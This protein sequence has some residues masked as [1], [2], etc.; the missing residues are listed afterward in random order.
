MKHALLLATRA[1][2]FDEVPVGALIVSEGRLIAQDFNRRELNNHPLHHAE[3]SVIDKASRKLKRWRLKGCTLYVTLEPCVMCSG[4]IV[5]SRLDRIVYGAS[6]LMAGGVEYLYQLL[7]DKRLN[8]RPSLTSGV[9][10][11]DC[12]RILTDFF[13]ELRRKKAPELQAGLPFDRP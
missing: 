13:G 5:N 6:D 9:L 10:E 4:A 8:H 3:L 7:S 11:K 12:S 2:R 1:A